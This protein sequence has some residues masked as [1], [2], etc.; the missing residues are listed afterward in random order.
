MRNLSD[1]ITNAFQSGTKQTTRTSKEYN[2]FVKSDLS[3]FSGKWIA[4]K[5]NKVV[6]NNHM[7]ENV[8]KTVQRKGLNSVLYAKI[9]RKN[10][11]SNFHF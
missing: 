4:I 6:A 5:D 10:E 9:P 8:T 2:F 3:K 7:I 1:F 11:C